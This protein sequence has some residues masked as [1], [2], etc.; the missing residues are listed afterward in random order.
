MR[1]TGSVIGVALFGSVVASSVSGIAP[2]LHEVLAIS[3]AL[4]LAT[5]GLALRMAGRRRRRLVEGRLSRCPAF[6]RKP[7]VRC[8]AG[9]VT[10]GGWRSR[11]GF[12]TK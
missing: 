7:V 10:I 2:G 6:R 3:I 11:S 8:D 1:Q 5:G 4:L 12:P 9:G